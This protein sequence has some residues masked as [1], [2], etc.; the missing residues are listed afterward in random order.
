MDL[1][2]NYMLCIALC[3]DIGSGLFKV[4]HVFARFLQGIN[5]QYALRDKT[6]HAWNPLAVVNLLCESSYH[7]LCNALLCVAMLII[8]TPSE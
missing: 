7:K 4:A 5:A 1:F 6:G 3:L 2:V 8:S